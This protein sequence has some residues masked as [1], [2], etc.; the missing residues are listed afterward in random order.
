MEQKNAVITSARIEIERGVLTMWLSL[1][2]GTGSQQGFGGYALYLPK[3]YRHSN[4]QSNFAGH[5]IYRVLTIAGVK[6]FD[7]LV[8]KSI[9]V[10]A[11]FDK[12]HAIG[13]I[14]KDEWYPIDE[15][16]NR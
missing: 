9:R 3:S 12:V 11:D 16:E 6:S 15:T 7:D 14:I 4:K 5:F 10:K 8:G 13:H 1:D 2:Y